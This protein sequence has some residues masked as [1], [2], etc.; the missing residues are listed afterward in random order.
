MYR[1]ICLVIGY[2]FGC[3]QFAYILGKVANNIDIRQYGSGNAGTTNV[4]RVM[5]WKAGVFTFVGDFLKAFIAVLLCKYLFGENGYLVGLYAGVGVIMGH[6]WPFYMHFKGGKGIA[7]TIGSIMAIDPFIGLITAGIMAI[8]LLLTRY[9][10]LG[11]LLMTAS[12]PVLLGIMY[13][14]H[15]NFLEII[16]LGCTITVFAFIRHRAN[17]KRLLTGKESKLGQRSN[18]KV[19]DN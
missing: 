18:K 6:N 10:S 14:G 15:V 12:I 5:G 17:I 9:V 1:L 3:I 7:A 2:A 8:V 13:R 16:A 11:A 4:I 19:E